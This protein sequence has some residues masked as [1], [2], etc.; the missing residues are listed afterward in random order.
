MVYLCNRPRQKVVAGF[1]EYYQSPPGKAKKI[2]KEERKTVRYRAKESVAAN[3]K[4]GKIKE[5]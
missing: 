3:H 4:K 1:S 5:A 2:S